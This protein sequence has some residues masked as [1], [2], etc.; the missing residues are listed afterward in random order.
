M[1]IHNSPFLLPEYK[2]ILLYHK[3]T[4][5]NP[6]I[7]KYFKIFEFFSKFVD[8]KGQSVLIFGKFLLCSR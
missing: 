4:F 7:L 6:N 3:Y 2:Y 1:V 5:I 8:K